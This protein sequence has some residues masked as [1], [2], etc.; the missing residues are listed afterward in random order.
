MIDFEEDPEQTI[1]A[2][3]NLLKQK[4]WAEVGDQMVIVTN[5]VGVFDKIV[6][7]MQVRPLE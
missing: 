5:V 1:H 3:F 7:S 2:A 4:N 6:D